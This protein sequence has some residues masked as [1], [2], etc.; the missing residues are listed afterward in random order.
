MIID[1]ITSSANTVLII[2]LKINTTALVLLII[3][4]ILPYWSL[5]N[6]PFFNRLFLTGPLDKIET[7]LNHFNRPCGQ[8]NLPVVIKFILKL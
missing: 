4:L 5:F 7:I 8:K 2:N 1:I 3:K 6:R